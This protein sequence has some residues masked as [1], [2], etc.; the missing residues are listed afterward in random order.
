M[1]RPWSY[2]ALPDRP[3]TRWPGGARVA[4]WVAVG[5]ESYRPD[6]GQTEDI[7]P[8]GTAPDLVNA[9]WRE[10]GNRVGAFRLFDRLSALGI[11]PTLLLNSDVCDE[12]PEVVAAARAID[13][14]IVAHG[15]SNSDVLTAMAADEEL[16]Y[17][18]ACR[19]RIAE[20]SGQPPAGWS[21]PWLAH[22]PTTLDHLAQAG[23]SYV[24]DFRLD[25]QPVWL[26]AGTGSIL[27]IPYAAELNDS[28]TMIGRH[29]S[30]ESFA[31]MILDEAEELASGGDRAVVMSVVLHSFISGQPFRLRALS[32]ALERIVARDEVWLATP[33]EIFAAVQQ[34][35][36]LATGG[37]PA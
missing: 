37:P 31:R 28:T 11:R 33:A 27:S 9:A 5:V 8:R 32:R 2:S 35:P 26:R 18:A 19:T 16:A 20:T 34:S 4:L 7:L 12:A 14:E 3:A 30:A 23:F 10:Y 1:T 6:E 21:S 22:R 17:I 29:T 15:Q 24:L 13:A 36:E 25:D